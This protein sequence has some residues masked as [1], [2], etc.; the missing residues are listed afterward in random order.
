MPNEQWTPDEYQ[1]YKR[2][3][4]L[5]L[6]GGIPGTNGKPKR[7]LENEQRSINPLK[8]VKSRYRLTITHYRHKLADFDNLFTKHFTDAIINSGILPDDTPETII[9]THEQIKIPTNLMEKTVFKI[10]RNVTK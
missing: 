4:Q 9:T 1:R 7:G 6:R 10:E 3:G 8:E 2:T 5:P